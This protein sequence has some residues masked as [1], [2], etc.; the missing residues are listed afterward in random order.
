VWMW[1]LPGVT[2]GSSSRVPT[3]DEIVSLQAQ[4][5]AAASGK[6]ASEVPAL[7]TWSFGSHQGLL[8]CYETDTG[9]AVLMWAYAGETLVCKAMR[10]DRD[11]ASLLEW[12]ADVARFG[13]S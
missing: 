11:M 9:D 10:D 12:W 5:V 6:C 3:P 7:E 13:P 4:R 8:L 1:R 2:G